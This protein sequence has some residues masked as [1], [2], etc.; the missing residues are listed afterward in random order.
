MPSTYPTQPPDHTWLM[1][2]QHIDAKWL[3]LAGDIAIA[4]AAVISVAITGMI[5]IRQYKNEQQERSKDR[6]LQIRNRIMVEG[7][8]GMV[9]AASTVGAAS[10]LSIEPSELNQR[11]Q[12]GLRDVTAAI[13][14]CSLQT[15]SVARTFHMGLMKQVMAVL[16]RRDAL[17]RMH[18][19]FE[20]QGKILRNDGERNQRLFD[21][22]Q[23]M[24]L[25]TA[26]AEKIKVAQAMIDI[27]HKAHSKLAAERDELWERLEKARSTFSVANLKR[28]DGFMPQV[29]QTIGSIRVDLGLPGTAEEFVAAAQIT[30]LDMQQIIREVFAELGAEQS[31]QAGRAAE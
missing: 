14:M 18:D 8:R 12:D 2:M 4:F 22:Q 26:D 24:M 29:Y 28:M 30:S 6:E 9:Q 10:D 27:S 31:P 1:V 16:V 25:G 19:E 17:I 13:A 21:T 3:S 20:L 7:I 11:L 5:A 15:V 23:A